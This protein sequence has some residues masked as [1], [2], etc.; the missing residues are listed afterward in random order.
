MSSEMKYSFLMPYHRRAEQ[1]SATLD[2][3]VRHYS[4]RHDFEII[5]GHDVKSAS[6]A[7]EWESLASVIRKY[8]DKFP[9]T[10]L[11]CGREDTY[12]PSI[13]YNECA[14]QAKGKFFIITNPECMH[15]VDV[16]A[17]FD[18]EFNENLFAYIICSC[19]SVSFTGLTIERAQSVFYQWY[20]H[21]EIRN[22]MC[23]FCTAIH[24]SQYNAIG[25]FSIEYAEGMCFEDDDFRN[26]II[27]NGNNIVTRD[28]LVVMHLKHDKS[29]PERHLELHKR[30]LLI[31]NNTWG[32]TAM[33]AEHFPLR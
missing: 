13:I 2:S 12:N 17:G 32:E 18:E 6:I 26:K 24:S 1:L 11:E 33:R 21:S 3:F 31:Y 23:H 5:I 15:L 9:I 7:G 16:L 25:G 30:N 29:K 22:I 4:N 10:A 8:A 19:R 14:K 28:D 27:K 20:Q